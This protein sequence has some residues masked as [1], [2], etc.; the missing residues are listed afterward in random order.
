M[1]N[2]E[3]YLSYL[4]DSYRKLDDDLNFSKCQKVYL[5]F[6]RFCDILIS[7]ILLVACFP[8]FILASVF[9]KLTSAGPVVFSQPRVGKDRKIIKVY[10]F[11]TML[12]RAPKN[13]AAAELYDRD[14]YITKVGKVLRLTSVDELPQLFNVLKGDMSLIGP[15]PLIP[16][17]K[18][19]HELRN[20]NSVYRIRPGITGL[21]QVNGRNLLDI[22][23]KVQFDTEYLHSLSLKL[24][25]YIFFKSIWVV[26]NMSGF[27]QNKK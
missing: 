7:F 17:E 14:E 25:L 4:N 23:S 24:D 21:A 2:K 9:I 8:I 27:F 16:E 22:N 13:K 10:K 6:K 1:E 19:A 3:L 12:T 20:K 5:V 18:E 15:R 11:R 26:F